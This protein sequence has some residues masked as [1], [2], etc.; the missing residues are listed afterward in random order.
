M[1]KFSIKYSLFSSSSSICEIS[2][3]VVSDVDALDYRRLTW[4]FW[5]NNLK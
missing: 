4:N 3:N 5:K 1:K 2:T